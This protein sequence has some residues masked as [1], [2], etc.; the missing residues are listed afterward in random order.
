MK[1]YLA[2]LTHTTVTVSI[3][4]FPL[5]IGYLAA[6]AS[7]VIPQKLDFELFRYPDDCF[8]AVDKAAPDVM[9]IANYCWNLELGAWALEYARKTNPNLLT[10]CGGPNFPMDEE[11]QNTFLKRLPQLDYYIVGDGEIPFTFLLERFIANGMNREK[12]AQEFKANPFPSTLT[13]DRGTD[14]MIK[15]VGFNRAADMDILPSPYQLGLLDK[16]FDGK[17]NPMIQTNRG[18]PFTCTFC[19]EGNSSYAKVNKFGTDRVKKDL[20]YI[21]T[22][23]HPSSTLFITDS[24]FGMYERDIETAQFIRGLQDKNGWPKS[25]NCTTGKNNP[26]GIIKVVDLVNGAIRISSS[27]QSMDSDVLL[28]VRRNNI[29]LES[30]AQVQEKVR[31]RNLQSVADLILCLPG[32]SKKSHFEGIKKLLDVG[33]QRVLPY[34]LMLLHGTQINNLETHQKYEFMVKH[35]VVPRNFGTYRGNQ[36]FESEAIVVGTNT[37]SHQDYLECRRLH[38]I[39]EAYY[40]ENPFAELIAYVNFCGIPTSD[41]F[42]A[43]NDNILSAPN[44]L[45]DVFRNF[46]KETQDELFDS[47]EELLTFMKQ[48]MEEIKEGKIGGNLLQK[49]SVNLWF[50]HLPSLVSYAVNIAYSIVSKKAQELEMSVEEI[51]EQLDSIEEYLKAIFVNV[52]DASDIRSAKTVKLRYDVAAWKENQYKQ[53]LGHFNE[54]PPPARGGIGRCGR[55]YLFAMD[56]EKARYVEDKLKAFGKTPQGVGKMLTRMFLK[57][58]RRSVQDK[59]EKETKVAASG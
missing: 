7:Q 10:V 40:K 33:V 50:H 13:F 31:E 49:Y 52:L 5:G 45:S 36:V 19:L 30:Y 25:I 24:N 4:T 34:Q 21:S 32:E 11:I 54:Q 43:L 14:R 20:E 9:A 15:G 16:F 55:D 56:E 44:D 53:S 8:D 35:R 46:T 17:L 41:F 1:V 38:L 51:R 12:L 2:D 58:L 48:H 39:L 27:V 42:F 57:D 59:Q 3:D 26:D 23:V 18:C 29:K 22:K 37:L 47:S 28:N 6:H